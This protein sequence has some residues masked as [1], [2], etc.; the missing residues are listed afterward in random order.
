MNV[1]KGFMKTLLNGCIGFAPC[2]YQPEVDTYGNKD[3]WY[4]YYI[5]YST[6]GENTKLLALELWDT[7]AIRNDYP[8]VIFYCPF[9]SEYFGWME[10]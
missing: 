10:S 2:V 8:T 9:D 6:D 1:S 5:C 4:K 7:T 3:F